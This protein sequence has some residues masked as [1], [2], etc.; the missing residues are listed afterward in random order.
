MNAPVLPL[1][2]N[3]ELDD[4]KEML[5]T[6]DDIWDGLREVTQLGD[7]ISERISKLETAI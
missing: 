3:K 7:K 4:V 5:N 1:D 6:L 2:L